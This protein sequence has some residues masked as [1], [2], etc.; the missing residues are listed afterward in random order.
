MTLRPVR[1]GAR[2]AGVGTLPLCCTVTGSLHIS[3]SQPD[4]GATRLDSWRRHSSVLLHCHGQNLTIAAGSRRHATNNG[5]WNPG[6]IG[7]A[8]GGFAAHY[9]L[10][11]LG[12]IV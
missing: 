12:V 5:D 7:L 10:L 3:P 9:T 1:E 4:P 8:G 11:I 2:T 6:I